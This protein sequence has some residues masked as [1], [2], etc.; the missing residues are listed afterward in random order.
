MQELNPPA[1]L[2]TLQFS[3][4]SIGPQ[5]PSK[6]QTLNSLEIPRPDKQ[7]NLLG[8]RSCTNSLLAYKT[9]LEGSLRSRLYP[10]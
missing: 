4:R 5:I 10:S 1:H 6:L 8:F 9:P 7:E 2:S 3:K